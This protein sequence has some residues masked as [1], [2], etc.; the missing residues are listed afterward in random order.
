VWLPI[1]LAGVAVRGR[2]VIIGVAELE[3]LGSDVTQTT[4]CHGQRA[5]LPNHRH[6]TP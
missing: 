5:S 3:R 2:L 4:R 1:L 6:D